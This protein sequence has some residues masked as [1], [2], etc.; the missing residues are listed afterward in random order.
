MPDPVMFARWSTTDSVGSKDGWQINTQLAG[1][2][3]SYVDGMKALMQ[4]AERWRLAYAGVTIYQDGASLSDNGTVA[5]AIVPTRFVE[6][7]GYIATGMP[8][9]YL[10]SLNKLRTLSLEDLRPST[11][12]ARCQMLISRSRKWVCTCP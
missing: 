10:P 4:N 12:S 7:G 9:G 11:A 1:S 6:P 5:A 2:A 8:T 3:G